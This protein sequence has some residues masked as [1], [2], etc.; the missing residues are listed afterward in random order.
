MSLEDGAPQEPQKYFLGLD[1]GSISIKA[2]LL[3]EAG[4]L[5]KPVWRRHFGRPFAV[6]EQALTELAGE[7]PARHIQPPVVT[8][9]A[10]ADLAALLGGEAVGE[11][12]ALTLAADGRAEAPASL[13]DIGGEDTKVLWFEQEEGELA[14]A[15]FAMNSMCAAGTGSF[16]DQQAH[17]LGYEIEEFG[18]LALKSEVPPRVAGRC[19]VFAKSDM[20]HLQ[21]SA[22]PDYEIIYGLCLAMARSVKSGLAK[23]RALPSPVLFTGGVAANPG[24]VRALGEVMGLD[25]TQ[26]LIPETHFV[27]GALGAARYALK[28]ARS[29]QPGLDL[30]A[31]RG[32]LTQGH[33]PPERLAPLKRRP[34][35][36]AQSSFNWR[37]V[38]GKLPVYIGVDVGSV[39][40]NIAL[41]TENGELVSRQYLPTAGR[42]LEAIALGFSAIPPDVRDKVKV[43]G[44]CT[45]GSGRYLSADYL[46]ADLTVNE[47]TAQA[48]AAVAIDPKVDTIFEIGGQD[49]KYISLAD[50]VIVD[51][52]MN[53]ACAAGTGSFLEEQAEKLGLKIKGEFGEAA[54]ASQSPVSLGERCTVFMESD[55]VHHQQKGVDH[56]DLSAGL[57]YGIVANYLGRVVESRPVGR[58]IFFQG[59]TS[60]NE[61]VAAA[62]EARLGRPITVPDNADVT[63][64][65][66]AALIARDRRDWKE[67]RFVG[68]DLSTRPY[69]IK[70]F[71]CRDCA[72]RCE[73]RQVTV[74]GGQPFFYGSRCGRF[75]EDAGRPKTPPRWP[76]LFEYRAELA[77]N[78]PE[79]KALLEKERGLVRRKIGM[80]RSMFFGEMGP[81]WATFWAALGFE[82]VWSRPTNKSIIHRGCERVG[83]EFC[84]PIK[85]AHGHL[86]DL[87]ALKP[88][89]IFLPS[90]VNLP[91]GGI[92]EGEEAK[93]PDS[94]ACPYVQSLAYTAPA[95]L[96][97]PRT[98]YLT[99]PVFF[100]EGEKVLLDSLA[101]ITKTLGLGK[102]KVREAMRLA[103]EAQGN[104]SRRLV[105]KGREMLEALGPEDKALVIVA[106][107]Y[108]GFDPGLNL[109]LNEKLAD[110]GVMGLPMDFLPLNTNEGEAA[111]HYWR[112]GQKITAAA[113]LIAE[114]PRLEALY[115]SNFGC[116]PDSFIIHFFRHQ[117]GG[118]PFLEIEID[119][120]SSDV[121]AVTRLEAFLDSLA[122]R[123]ARGKEFVP[124]EEVAPLF[125][126]RAPRLEKTVYIPPMCD[127]VQAAAAAL[128]SVGL[129]AVALPPSDRET[130]E[131]GRSQTSGKECFPLIL[132]VGDFI[133]LT[134][135]PGFDPSQSSVFMPSSNGPCRF[136]QYGRYIRLVMERMG[137]SE[138]DVVSLDQTGGMYQALDAAGGRSGEPS[139]TRRFWRALV[140][141]DL[142]QKALWQTRPREAVRGAADSAYQAALAD[143]NVAVELNEDLSRV[144]K[145]ARDRFELATD[146][147]IPPGAKP[148]VG[149][150]GEIYVRHNSFA[151]EDVIRRLEDLGAEVSA[152]P[153]AEWIFYVGFVNAMRAGR[154]GDWKNRLRHRL[155][156]WLQSR[157]YKTLAKPWHGFFHQGAIDPPVKGVVRL[158]EKFLHRSFQGEAILSLG[159]GLE[160][161][162]HEAC[163]LVNIMPFTCMPGMVVGGLTQ[164]LR[165]ACGGMPSLNLSFDGQSQTNTQ[166]R[167]EAFMYQVKSFHQRRLDARHK[168]RKGGGRGH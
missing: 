34:K 138:L 71:E 31:L 116:G 97:Q 140:A 120:H 133:K 145:T 74:A 78:P 69:T 77:F 103:L 52:M 135:R 128:R 162:Q 134:R 150:V 80:I 153:F 4:A 84:F 149:L 100:G 35:P 101:E 83:S 90:L 62:F 54:L 155:I 144:M 65:M 123:R 37:L 110:L 48:T 25:E 102:S 27:F 57:C 107:P 117:L 87:A 67:S 79:A 91:S 108:N 28:K 156:D 76:D 13:V 146:R 131:L 56:Q 137:L 86:L 127:H 59:G 88:D 3:D 50:G 166:A 114:D 118:K 151:N 158:G 115:I 157:D 96:G 113:D 39:S 98:D 106:R 164:N 141:I 38:L 92:G 49:S 2:A 24:L 12:M 130:I 45:T 63:G 93:T 23:G 53:K 152:P 160:F 14:L 16:L 36:P 165:D 122:A 126:T 20:I 132:T 68:F 22:T 129:P 17:R 6:V 44:V 163:G 147:S 11:V 125:L 70:S 109:R 136:G 8:G 81:F 64:A 29:E 47:I 5:L 139:L 75:E 124:E 19:S 9:S 7:F 40:T 111:S 89:Y 121:G 161:Y 72:N 159:K 43:L 30:S 18:R 58:H 41:V 46:G 94:A 143:L 21:Q 61:G 73:I 105:E 154:N 55:L 1:I 51:F 119:E 10:A 95:A 82:P 15:D 167:L 99:G 66:G 42:P 142:I 33:P 104:F 32:F 148:R 60:F 85:A 168:G 112:Y 26:L